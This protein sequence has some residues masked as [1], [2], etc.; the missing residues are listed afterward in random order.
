MKTPIETSKLE[1]DQASKL[2]FKTLDDIIGAL[3][4][5]EQRAIRKESRRMARE[6]KTSRGMRQSRRDT[7]MWY[8]DWILR[9]YHDDELENDMA[10]AWL[11]I[12]SMKLGPEFLAQQM[13]TLPTWQRIVQ[14][15][16][17]KK[18][19]RHPNWKIAL[20]NKPDWLSNQDWV[21]KKRDY[22]AQWGDRANDKTL[23]KLAQR[24]CEG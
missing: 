6:M 10:G 3:P 19:Q 8:A 23:L 15:H 16:L 14:L 21:T 22:V 2:T 12:E 7:L 17:V 4:F 11:L 9:P 20:A 5:A 18:I 13:W 24:L 1:A